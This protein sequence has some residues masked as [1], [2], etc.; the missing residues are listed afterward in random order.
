MIWLRTSSWLFRGFLVPKNGVLEKFSPR[1]HQHKHDDILFQ[2]SFMQVRARTR[3]RGTSPACLVAPS[4][5]DRISPSAEI[6]L[7]PR[8]DTFQKQLSPV[9][10]SNRSRRASVHAATSVRCWT[11]SCPG[12]DDANYLLRLLPRKIPSTSLLQCRAA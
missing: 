10:N 11:E 12:K 6:S 9:L 4:Y 5:L 2:T 3:S 7:L 1:D 8:P